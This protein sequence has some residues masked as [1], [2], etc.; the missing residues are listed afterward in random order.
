MDLTRLL[1]NKRE[2]VLRRWFDLIVETYPG[3]SQ[4]FLKKKSPIGN[5]VGV[6]INRSLAGLYDDLLD[7]GASER[8]LSYLDEV[9]RIRAVQEFTP[10]QATD[11]IFLLKKAIREETAKEV[12]DA[13]GLRQL[14][15]LE[16]KIDELARMAFDLHSRCREQLY[17]MRVDEVKRRVSGLLRRHNLKVDLPG[18]CPGP[19]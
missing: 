2:S 9:I 13:G 10:S 3:L 15:D 6:N 18:S 8:T 5:P 16:L 12:N 19:E 7:A 4:I 17:E 1:W 14:M 11:A